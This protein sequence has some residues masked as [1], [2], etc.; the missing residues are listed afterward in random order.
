MWAW[1]SFNLPKLVEISMF[2]TI[3]YLDGATAIGGCLKDPGGGDVNTSLSCFR[4][5]AHDLVIVENICVSDNC[6]DFSKGA[7]RQLRNDSFVY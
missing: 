4:A 7:S 2:M 6:A 3:I 1:K 5:A